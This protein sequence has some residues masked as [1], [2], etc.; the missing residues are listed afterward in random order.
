MG[1][2]ENRY[3]CIFNKERANEYLVTRINDVFNIKIDNTIGKWP[4]N[5]NTEQHSKRIIRMLMYKQNMIEF[6]LYFA[7]DKDQRNAVCDIVIH[8]ETGYKI[9]PNVKFQKQF[10]RLTFVKIIDDILYFVF[11][12]ENDVLYSISLIGQ[13]YTITKYTH[14][15]GQICDIWKKD[16]YTMIISVNNNN[17]KETGI[18][19]LEGTKIEL[20]NKFDYFIL[21]Y[22]YSSNG[23]IGFD[24]NKVLFYK[25]KNNKVYHINEFS[26]TSDI[27][28]AAFFL[29]P[30]LIIIGCYKLVDDH[31]SNFLFGG[32]YE[33]KLYKYCR[34]QLNTSSYSY[35]LKKVSSIFQCF[36]RLEQ[37]VKIDILQT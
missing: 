16:E 34:L 10:Y 18:F 30:D 27:A 20:I 5:S 26:N 7:Y 13:E 25:D 6:W 24:K 36:W 23:I 29:Q 14:S 28:F 17:R 33:M 11:S 8:N 21:E 2:D 37:L 35:D 12:D 3:I 1:K 4:N 31:I 22:D 32:G 15:I 19:V 9:I